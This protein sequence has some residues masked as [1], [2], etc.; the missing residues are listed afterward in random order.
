MSS[1]SFKQQEYLAEAYRIAH[2]QNGDPF[3]STSHLAQHMHVSAPA[4]TRMVQRLKEA[5]YVEHEP[6][7][8]IK[9]TLAGEQEALQNI[10]RHRIVERFLVDLMGFGWHEVHEAADS[11]SAA[12]SDKVV[13]RMAAMLNFPQRCPHGEPIPNAAGKMPEVKDS[14]LNM[15][16]VGDPLVISRVNT[17]DASLL[18]YLAAMGIKPGVGLDLMEVAPFNGPLRVRINAQE[19][20]LGHE[21]GAVLRVC[22]PEHFALA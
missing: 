1:E 2:Y 11:M 17:H 15:R 18:Q 12:T 10:R 22:A 19:Q 21:V 20:F 6:Y 5:G 7:R 14:P 16:H 13:A 9:L 8:G 3:V 4:V